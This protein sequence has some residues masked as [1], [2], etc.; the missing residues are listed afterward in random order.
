MVLEKTFKWLGKY[1]HSNQG[2]GLYHP[3]YNY[4]YNPNCID[5]QNKI[6]I[7][8][9]DNTVYQPKN[10]GAGQMVSKKHYLYGTFE[11][12]YILPKGDNLWPAI[13]LTSAVTWPPE[14]DVMEGWS[15]KNNYRKRLIFNNI[16]PNLHFRR[17]P[18]APKENYQKGSLGTKYTFRCIHKMNGVNTCKLIWTPDLIEISYNNKTIMKVVDK[19]LLQYFNDPMLVIMNNAVTTEFNNTDYIHYKEKG[20]PFSILDFK[21]TEYK[22]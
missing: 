1:Y 4:W 3:E 10:F 15:A 18:D 16:M 19:D 11:W 5:I 17:T 21:Y 13:W 8:D 22:S 2:W 6:A 7:L 20:R 14:I 9:V 12:E